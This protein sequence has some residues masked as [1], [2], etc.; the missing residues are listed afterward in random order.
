VTALSKLGETVNLTPAPSSRVAVSSQGNSVILE[1]MSI[2]QVLSYFRGHSR[3]SQGIWVKC[4]AHEDVSPSLAV[5]EI[6]P[7]KIELRCRAGCSAGAVLKGLPWLTLLEPARDTPPPVASAEPVTTV[8]QQ[9]PA[10]AFT[11][12][13]PKSAT[14]SLSPLAWEEIGKQSDTPLTREFKEQAAQHLLAAK[15]A[16]AAL[17]GESKPTTISEGKRAANLHATGSLV[18][19]AIIVPFSEV[20]RKPLRWCWP[21]RLPRGKLSILAG[22]PDLGKSLVTIDV[23]ARVSTGRTFPDGAPCQRGEAILLSAEDDECDTILPRLEAAGADLTR[24]HLL[25]AVR[26][27]AEDGRSVESLFSLEKDLPVLEETLQEHPD[28][29]LVVI[30]P[31]SSYLG[32]VDSHV[33][34]EVRGALAPLVALAAKC[35]VAV[36]M[37]SHFRK[38]AGPAIYRTLGSVG[39]TAAGRATWAVTTDLEDKELRLFLRV[40]ANLAPS[41]V[42]GLAYKI[43]SVVDL[44]RWPEFPNGIPRVCW[45]PG[46][47][48]VED[49]DTALGSSESPELRS[50][51]RDAQEWLR[52]YLVDGPVEAGDIYRAASRVGIARVTLWRAAKGIKVSRR[53]LGGRGQGWEWSLPGDGKPKISPA[54]PSLPE[55]LK[56]LKSSMTGK[57]L[58]KISHSKISG[59]IVEQAGSSVGGIAEPEGTSP[60]TGQPESE[61]NE[62][63]ALPL[64]GTPEPSTEQ[65]PASDGGNRQAKPENDVEEL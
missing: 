36:V 53:K 41:S 51:R 29:R 63:L 13:A 26:T 48:S 6:G 22:D 50:E 46:P 23:M 33:N 1:R 43:E 16:D 8:A 9:K 52:E 58:P 47:V 21:E 60:S 31:I 54:E 61:P 38:G 5:N 65:K 57:D 30:D 2:E 62:S 12:P 25:K 20:E 59:E 15:I 3:N 39:F 49:L 18:S 45:R 56:S 64:L 19:S 40:K 24:V 32:S 44:N 10:S 42:G 27:T 35:A 11:P 55:T 37:I 4:P 34:A 7:R 17:H 28:T 14:S